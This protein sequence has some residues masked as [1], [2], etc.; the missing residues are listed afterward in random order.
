MAGGAGGQV[1]QLLLE[2]LEDPDGGASLTLRGL[3]V[4]PEAIRANLGALLEAY[5]AA[6]SVD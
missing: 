3:G 5:A 6:D 2:A 1:E 4:D